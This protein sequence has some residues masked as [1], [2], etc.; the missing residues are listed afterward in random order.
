MSIK[1]EMYYIKTDN[2][3]TF[4][5]EFIYIPINKSIFQLY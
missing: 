4:E 3:F 1:D 5:N 2:S